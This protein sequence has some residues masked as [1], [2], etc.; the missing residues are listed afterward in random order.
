MMSMRTRERSVPVSTG[1]PGKLP[2]FAVP[3]PLAATLP[4]HPGM[5]LKI[6]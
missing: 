4:T 6:R 3:L 5:A 1:Y 2:G